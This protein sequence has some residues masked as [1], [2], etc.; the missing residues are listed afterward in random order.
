MKDLERV[1]GG[2][3]TEIED[4]FWAIVAEL[5][6]GVNSTKITYYTIA[7][8]PEGTPLLE[9]WT[10]QQAREVEADGRALGYRSVW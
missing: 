7:F 6:R 5:R 3:S 2:N 8:G 9:S 4:A 1:E 10:P